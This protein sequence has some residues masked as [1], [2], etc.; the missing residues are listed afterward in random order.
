MIIGAAVLFLGSIIGFCVFVEMQLP[1]VKIL[2]DVHMQAPL[3]VYSKEG[4]LI[5]EYGA[6]RRM[7]VTLDQVP[8]P[9]IQAILATEDQRFYSHPGVDFIGLFRAFKVLIGTG[10]KSQGASTITMQVARNFFLSHKKTY[11]R[12]VREIMLALKIERKFSKDKILELYLNKVYFGNHAYGVAAAAN[13]YYGKN[14]DQLTL[15]EI[16]MIAGLPQAPSKNNPIVR[17][18]AAKERRDHVLLRMLGVGDI[19]TAQYQQAI[20]EADNASY[21]GPMVSVNAPYVGE[22]VRQAM[23][24][25][26]GEKVYDQGY[27]VYT[28]I[29]GPL[30][31][32]AT[33]RLQEGLIEYTEKHDY[34]A[35][36]QTLSQKGTN[37]PTV[38]R[39]TLTQMTLPSNPLQ[40]AA[41]YRIGNDRAQAA[42]GSGRLINLSLEGL[43]AK[44]GDIIWV[45]QVDNNWQVDNLPQIQGALISINPQN[46]AVLAAVG[47]FDFT[48]SQFNRVTQAQR[49]PGSLF[50]PFIYSA[51]L[52]KGFTLASTINNAPIV[53]NDTGED[54]IW[55]PRNDDRQFTGLTRLREG[56]VHSLNLVSIRLLQQLGIP[57]VVDF[58]SRFGFDANQ[59]PHSLSLALGTGLTSPLNMVTGYS[60][61]ANGGYRVTPYFIDYVEDEDKNIIYK[62][63]PLVACSA[64]ITDVNAAPPVHSAPKVLDPQNAYMINQALKSVI[65]EGTG[66]AAKV[67]GR[68]DLAGKT[69]TTND[70]VDAWFSGFNSQIA[71]T[72]W[73]GYD[74]LT[75]THEYGSELAL[76]IWIKYMRTALNNIP[77]S[78]MPRPPGIVTARIDPQTGLLAGMDQQDAIFEIFRQGAEPR[79][80]SA[81]S[82][83]GGGAAAQPEDIF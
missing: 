35:P 80:Q 79:A 5:A 10:Q 6:S 77:I 21:H 39:E 74:D 8:K 76:A 31:N 24:I 69:G 23:V 19:T 17:P 53:I 28:T 20:K 73:I 41:V 46:G 11:I 22:S 26:F 15:A 43:S 14:L 61:F 58:A 52:D 54:K 7:P 13:V 29:S 72:V 32:E 16:A 81:E 18:K 49:Q 68:P 57:Y 60:V 4:Q 45:R 2:K 51:A 50:K 36:K 83:G 34:I 47:G 59:L 27:S 70:K 62:F 37:W 64:C 67:L 48:L 12:K 33:L 65:T 9:L 40:P 1:D 71:T 63:N 38:W 55:R 56:L 42:L 66:Q 30:Q 44:I 82:N 25:Q 78:E 3:R 75:P